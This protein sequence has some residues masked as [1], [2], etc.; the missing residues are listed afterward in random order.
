M[1]K[2]YLCTLKELF[3]LDVDESEK[4]LN[5]SKISIPLIQRDYAQ[6]RE[7]PDTTS[8]RKKFLS[9]NQ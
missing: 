8:I 2:S 4:V 3:S 6:G 1:A 9:L 5:V 7:H